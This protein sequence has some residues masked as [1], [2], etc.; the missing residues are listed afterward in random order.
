MRTDIEERACALAAYVIDNKAT[1]RAAAKKFG[2]SKSTVHKDISER[3]EHIDRELYTRAKEILEVNKAERHI[4]GGLA[5]RQK[6]KG[7]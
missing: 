4:R 5:T 6:Y 1:V 7:K 2:I 3:L